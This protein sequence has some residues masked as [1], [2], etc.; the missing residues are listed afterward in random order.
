MRR[1]RLERDSE[2]H[3]LRMLWDGDE[4]VP[5]ETIASPL[6]FVD[7]RCPRKGRAI[8]GPVRRSDSGECETRSITCLT[9]GCTGDRSENLTLRKD[10]G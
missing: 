10:H 1:Y 3:L 4:S 7:G 8:L 2:G 5:P 9:C 6:C